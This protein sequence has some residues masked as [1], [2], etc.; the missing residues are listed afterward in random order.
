MDEMSPRIQQSQQTKLSF[1]GRLTS[2]FLPEHL[3]NT[4]DFFTGVTANIVRMLGGW[5]NKKESSGETNGGEWGDWKL[6][7]MNWG[8]STLLPCFF[9]I[10]QKGP[11]NFGSSLEFLTS[12]RKYTMSPMS[13]E[14]LKT[15]L[16]WQRN[17]PALDKASE[18]WIL[19]CMCW[20][21]WSFVLKKIC[22]PRFCKVSSMTGMGYRDGSQ[23]WDANHLSIWKQETLDYWNDW[24]NFQ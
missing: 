19:C 1:S 17:M 22:S 5:L 8:S 15:Y 6:S 7:G 18:C 3:Q 23:L 13:G 14:K 9:A 16:L 10:T 2:T 12:T 24:L 20:K 21:V 11:S 4:C